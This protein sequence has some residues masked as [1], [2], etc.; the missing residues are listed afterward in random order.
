MKGTI[1][2]RLDLFMKVMLRDYTKTKIADMIEIDL[3]MLSR[4][5]NGSKIPGT[6]SLKKIARLGIS[7]NWLLLGE[8]ALISS[9]EYGKRARNIFIEDLRKLKATLDSSDYSYRKIV[10][11]IYKHYGTEENFYTHLENNNIEYNKEELDDFF[12]GNQSV[13]FSIEEVLYKTNIYIFIKFEDQELLSGIKLVIQN[14]EAYN[15]Q[16]LQSNCK[17]EEILRKIKGLISEYN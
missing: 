1:A 4:Y 3:P 5:T 17:A 13:S 8:G 11:T 6:D 15:N 7:I 14:I 10:E 9:D 16:F 2:E 12:L